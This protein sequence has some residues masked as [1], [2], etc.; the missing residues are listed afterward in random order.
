MP[1]VRL[2]ITHT[3]EG[4]YQLDVRGEGFH[5]AEGKEVDVQLMGNDPISDDRLGVFFPTTNVSAGK[6][7]VSALVKSKTLDDDWGQDEIYAIADVDTLGDFKSNTVKG[8]RT[9]TT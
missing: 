5:Q 6:F 7:D 2:S 1:Q 4:L 3:E 8:P 9:T